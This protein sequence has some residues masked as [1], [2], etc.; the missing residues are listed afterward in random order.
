M[1]KG[2]SQGQ[3]GGGHKK[4]VVEK[5]SKDVGGERKSRGLKEGGEAN[6]EGKISGRTTGGVKV[7]GRGSGVTVQGAGSLTVEGGED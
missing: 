4:N 1:T 6:N 3:K 7:W 5:K 2:Q